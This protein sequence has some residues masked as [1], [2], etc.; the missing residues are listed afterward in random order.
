LSVFPNPTQ[1]NLILKIND[2]KFEN[3]SFQII[4]IKGMEIIKNEIKNDETSID[5]SGFQRAI[6]FLKIISNNKLIQTFK[7]IKN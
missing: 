2:T 4:D 6:Y 1:S 3:L 7:I 5:F